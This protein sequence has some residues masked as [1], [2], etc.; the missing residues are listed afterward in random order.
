MFFERLTLVFL[1]QRERLRYRETLRSLNAFRSS[2]KPSLGNFLRAY[3]YLWAASFIFPFWRTHGGQTFSE[4]EDR[5]NKKTWRRER[6]R[7]RAMYSPD[8]PTIAV[9]WL[10]PSVVINHT[11]NTQASSSNTHTLSHTHL[12]CPF[13]HKTESVKCQASIMA[14]LVSGAEHTHLFLFC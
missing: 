10:Q 7:S 12:I 1:R 14:P 2:P 9:L 13:C 11:Y 8:I 3:W 6:G 4:E 5:T